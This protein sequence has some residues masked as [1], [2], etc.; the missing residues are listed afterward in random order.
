MI[1]GTKAR[2]EPR[3]PNSLAAIEGDQGCYISKCTRITPENEKCSIV[4]KL[5]RERT[6][7]Q[8]AYVY[9]F[10]LLRHSVGRYCQCRNGGQRAN[11]KPEHNWISL[12]KKMLDLLGCLDRPYFGFQASGARLYDLIRFKYFYCFHS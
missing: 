11:Y 4:P 12:A 7:I 8:R 5:G 6:L 1:Q 10:P 2:R 3:T 9:V